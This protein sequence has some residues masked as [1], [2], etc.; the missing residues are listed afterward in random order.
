MKTIHAA[1]I[2][3]VIAKG[4]DH[5]KFTSPV[6]W[7]HQS[8]RIANLPLPLAAPHLGKYSIDQI[9][10]ELGQGYNNP[11]QPNGFPDLESEWISKEL[12]ERRARYAVAACRAAPAALDH[13][14][15]FAVRLAGADSDLVA[16]MRAGNDPVAAAAI[17]LCSPQFLR[18]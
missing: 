13:V 7:L 12:L 4:R 14:M 15:E 2:D 11:P 8:H 3:E 10:A 9:C 16:N 5:T 18:I 1:V 17:L 6:V